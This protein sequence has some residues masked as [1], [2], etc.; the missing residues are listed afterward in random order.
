MFCESLIAMHVAQIST[1]LRFQNHK[2]ERP[3]DCT[4][5]V[6]NCHIS[7]LK[8]KNMKTSHHFITSVSKIYFNSKLSIFDSNIDLEY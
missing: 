1:N 3:K 6:Q 5:I 8:G 2:I 7:H 4:K